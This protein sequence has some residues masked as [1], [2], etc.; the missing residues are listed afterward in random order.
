MT[1]GWAILALVIIIGI[2]VSTGALSPTYLISEECSLGSNLPC[3]FALYNTGDT[4][5]I[6]LGLQNGFAYKINVTKVQVFSTA[7]SSAF[8]GFVVPE[9]I[10][11]GASMNF[12]GKMDRQLAPN[13]IARFYANITYS[14]CAP[15][16]AAPGQECSSSQHT[17][18]GRI[19]AKV[20]PG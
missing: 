6:S 4:T 11:S 3:T 7:D 17:I 12:T 8:T 13:S 19:T 18:V 16:L 14:S 10:E 2:L 1:Y 5:A 9:T 20:I 15:E